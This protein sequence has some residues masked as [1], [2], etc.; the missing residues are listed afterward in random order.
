MKMVFGLF[1]FFSLSLQAQEAPGSGG[2]NVEDVRGATGAASGDLQRRFDESMK[3]CSNEKQQAEL[4]CNDPMKCSSGMNPEAQQQLMQLT[5]MGAAGAMSMMNSKDS[6]LS[7]EGIAGLC[8]MLSALGSA[9]SGVNSGAAQVCEDTKNACSQACDSAANEWRS[10]KTQCEGGGCPDLEFLNS[11]VQQFDDQLSG[12]SQLSANVDA[13]QSQG[14]ESGGAGDMGQFCSQIAGMLPASAEEQKAE[15]LVIDCNSPAQATNPLCI[16]CKL[17]PENKACGNVVTSKE[18]ALGYAEASALS[19]SDFNTGMGIDGLNQEPVFGQFEPQANQS[20]T[21][22]GQ[23]GGIPGGGNNGGGFG[24]DAQTAS[25]G[26]GGYN[27]NILN[28]ERGGGGYSGAGGGS[29]VDSSGGFSGYGNRYAT[30]ETLPYEGMDLK[31][32]LPGGALDP[33]RRLA[34]ALVNAGQINDKSANIFERISSRMKAVCKT[35]RLKDCQ[36]IR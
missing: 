3:A 7:A 26:G 35:K 20:G 2:V 12:C 22:S 13:M 25:A 27:T 9:G 8:G 21:V 4:C 28:G 5:A 32:F 14:K 17:D 11:A 16:D 19:E 34:G 30:D 29:D 18:S 23:G 31:K 6:G 36:N 24:S 33:S 10:L 1:I 15:D